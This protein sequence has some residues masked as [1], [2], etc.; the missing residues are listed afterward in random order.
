MEMIMG[1]CSKE[2]PFEL[3]KLKE[4]RISISTAIKRGQLGNVPL[5][6][7]LADDIPYDAKKSS[8]VIMGTVRTRN[9]QDMFENHRSRTGEELDA[10]TVKDPHLKDS[11]TLYMEDESGLM[12]VKVNRWLYPKLKDALWDIKLGHD[13]VLM[14]VEKKPFFGK[15]VHCNHMWVIDPDD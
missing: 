2:D 4:G 15:T 5:P 10:A 1:F 13:F 12:T 9:L 11:M 14:R 3:D 6:N 8:H 7:T